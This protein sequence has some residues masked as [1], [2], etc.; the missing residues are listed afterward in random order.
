MVTAR[1]LLK[2]QSGL[3]WS[4]RMKYMASI[5]TF[6]ES[7]RSQSANHNNPQE[8]AMILKAEATYNEGTI[9]WPPRRDG[10]VY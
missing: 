6:E 8:Q 4:Q 7:P 10:V 2:A 3:S 1:L 5:Y 9:V